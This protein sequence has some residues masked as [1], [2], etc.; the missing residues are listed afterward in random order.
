MNGGIALRV[1]LN[2]CSFRTKFE[3][4][5]FAVH[6][7]QAGYRTAF[8]GKYL[9]EYDGSYIPPGWDYWTGLVKN[10]RFYNYTLNHNGRKEKHG[11]DYKDDYLTDLITKETLKFIEDSWRPHQQPFLVVLSYPAPVGVLHKN[12]F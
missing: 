4:Q 2:E 11:F 10:S 12:K 7:Q 8:F 9:N 6:L 1:T 5:T 3:N